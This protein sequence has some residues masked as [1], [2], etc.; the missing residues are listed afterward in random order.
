MVLPTISE[1]SPFIHR[2]LGPDA[3]ERDAML[4]TV[5]YSTLDELIEAALPAGLAQESA[6]ELPPALTEA[7]AQQRLRVRVA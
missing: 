3:T 1:S 4:L 5:G 2:H 7:Q 6:P